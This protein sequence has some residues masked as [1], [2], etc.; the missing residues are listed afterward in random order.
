MHKI[1]LPMSHA[2]RLR[3][4][5]RYPF[6]ASVAA[7]IPAVGRRVP[8]RSFWRS[9]PLGTLRRVEGGLGRRLRLGSSAEHRKGAA[10]PAVRLITPVRASIRRIDRRVPF[11]CTGVALGAFVMFYLDP[12]QGRRRRA[13]VR[14]KLAHFGNLFTKKVPHTVERRVRFFEGVAQ[15]V[16]HDVAE[17]VGGG[18]ADPD[19]DDDKLVARVRAQVLRNRDLRPGEIHIDAYEGCVTLRGQLEHPEEIRHLIDE[20]SHVEGV[21]EVR[22]YLHLPGTPAP[23]KAAS[24]LPAGYRADFD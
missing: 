2:V 20:S 18:G 4:S 11:V 7:R 14:D 1:L 8:A 3:N 16:A 23:N 15:G 19:L 5:Y 6:Q 24:Y 21:R 13:L 17:L 9:Q 12:H 22:S 10:F